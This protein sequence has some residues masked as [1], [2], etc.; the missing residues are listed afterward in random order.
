VLSGTIVATVL[1]A[2][3]YAAGITIFGVRVDGSWLGLM[4]V[5]V[6][7]GFLTSSFGLLIAS[8]GR[9][10]E[11]T[12]GIAILATLLLVMLGGAWVPTFIFPEWLQGLTLFMPTRWAVDGLEAMTWRGLGLET[13][14]PAVAVM[15]T[16]SVAFAAIAVACFRWEE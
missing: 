12:R 2:G 15:L 9:T 14:L 16:F 5:I 11:A 4:L 13:A 1:M 7:F 3:I 6:A 10:P 8:V